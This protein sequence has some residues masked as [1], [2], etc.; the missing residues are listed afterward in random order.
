MN[1]FKE[2]NFYRLK[3]IKEFF[4]FSNKEKLKISI[5]YG[6]LGEK[7]DFIFIGVRFFLGELQKLSMK[8]QVWLRW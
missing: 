8:V 7:E 1:L 2:Q 6:I 3:E 4:K 5:C